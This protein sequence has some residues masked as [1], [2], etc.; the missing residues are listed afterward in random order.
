M[1]TAFYRTLVGTFLI[2]GSAKGAI[3]LE[4]RLPNPD[5]RQ[6]FRVYLERIPQEEHEGVLQSLQR[7]IREQ[8]DGNQWGQIIRNLHQAVPL[9][10][11]EEF[12][13]QVNGFFP[14][15]VRQDT[16]VA[17]IVRALATG[18]SDFRPTLLNQMGRLFQDPEGIPESFFSSMLLTAAR[19]VNGFENPNLIIT[20]CNRILGHQELIPLGPEDRAY[21]IRDFFLV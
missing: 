17:E 5:H 21:K 6:T 20:L 13:G 11:R 16:Y 2:L 8:P 12:L 15:D 1:K 3:D 7:I 19:T 4:N 18:R 9:G 14:N 10:L